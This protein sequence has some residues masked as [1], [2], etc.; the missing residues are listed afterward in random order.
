MV[1]KQILAFGLL[2]LLVLPCTAP[3]QDKQPPQKANGTEEKQTSES[4]ETLLEKVKKGD[5]TIDFAALRIA[6]TKTKDFSGYGGLDRRA[7]FGAMEQKDFPKAL[8][9]AE[10]QLAKNF[11]DLNAH[12]VAFI[13][14]RET[15]K[16]EKAEWHRTLFLKLIESIEKSGDGKTPETAY[17]VIS[18]NEE[19]VLLNY[20]GY[21]P[22]GQ[23]LMRINGHTYDKLSVLNPKTK[24]K[25]EVYFQ[26]DAFFGKL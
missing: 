19:Y 12:Y 20:Q 11:V 18:T 2:L 23:A 14:N 7:A 21:Q 8:R 13:A 4:Y 17:I 10:E 1:R 9:L 15:G 16:A 3:A 25:A 6:Y 5:L 26:I 24:E 22:A